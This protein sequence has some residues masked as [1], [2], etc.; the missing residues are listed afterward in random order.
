MSYVLLLRG[1]PGSGKSFGSMVLM[2]K[3]SFDA[4]LHTDELYVGYIVTRKREMYHDKLRGVI[5][6]HYLANRDKL[7]A[8]W[9]AYLTEVV[10]RD[11]KRTQRLLVEGWHLT[12]CW[13]ALTRQLTTRGHVVDNVL[14]AGWEYYLAPPPRLG[15]DELA[16]EIR[17][18][19]QQALGGLT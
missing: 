12:L 5:K 3:D 18:K 19:T 10:S 17:V 9:E 4:V 6:D 2:A 15:L 14:A 13:D 11:A 16:Q 8:G 1:S 7:E